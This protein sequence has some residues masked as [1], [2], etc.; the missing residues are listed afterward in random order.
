[1]ITKGIWFAWGQSVG[2]K[3]IGTSILA[4]TRLVGGAVA[5]IVK[6]SKKDNKDPAT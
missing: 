4:K 3:G 6:S 5:P 1:M 2:V